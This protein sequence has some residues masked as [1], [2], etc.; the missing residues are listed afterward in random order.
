MTVS[1]DTLS[2][3]SPVK[4]RGLVKISVQTNEMYS[5][6]VPFPKHITGDLK[7]TVDSIYIYMPIFKQNDAI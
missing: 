6:W 7:D 2:F 1:E 5:Y 3:I 4:I